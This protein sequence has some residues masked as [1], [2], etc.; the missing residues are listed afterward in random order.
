MNL[1]SVEHLPLWNQKPL[2][3]DSFVV[4]DVENISTLFLETIK[5]MASFTPHKRFALSKRPLSPKQE[6]RLRKE[7]FTLFEHY[8]SSADAKI[9]RIIDSHH[10]CSALMLISSDGDFVPVIKRFLVKRPVQ[11][12]LQDE[13]KKR[14][15]MLI[16]LSHPRLTLSTFVHEHSRTASKKHSWKRQRP[17]LRNEKAW[18]AFFKRYQW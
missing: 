11:W 1:P 4:W 14:I 13:N 9:V 18:L 16:D 5:Q 10:L 3:K 15:C 7:G 6:A 8:P 2:V 12:I 17:P